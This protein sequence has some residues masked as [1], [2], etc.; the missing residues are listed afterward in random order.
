MNTSNDIADSPDGRLIT[1]SAC[2]LRIPT[3]TPYSLQIKNKNKN[4][5]ISR[6]INRTNLTQVNLDTKS[7]STLTPT[8]NKNK[9][10]EIE[11]FYQNIR[12]LRSRTNEFYINVLNQEHD[13]LAIVETWLHPGIFDSEIIDSRYQVFR[14]DSDQSVTGKELGRGLLLAIRADLQPVLKPDW[15]VLTAELELLWVE[16]TLGF[17]KLQVGLV[18]IMQSTRQEDV[19][20]QLFDHL[21]TKINL[22]PKNL[23][24]LGDF[25]IKYFPYNDQPTTD[26]LS[27]KMLDFITQYEITTH[28]IIPNMNNRT[29]DLVLYK[30]NKKANSKKTYFIN[31]TREDSLVKVEDGHHP[32]LNINI[33]YE[34]KHTRQKRS[35][36]P[37]PINQEEEEADAELTE[38]NLEFTQLGCKLFNYRKLDNEKLIGD[39]SQA[40]WSSVLESQCPNAS[41]SAFYTTLYQILNNN[42][43]HFPD[44]RRKPK[45]SFPTWWFSKTRKIFKEKSQQ[46]FEKKLVH[47]NKKCVLRRVLKLYQM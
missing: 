45:E 39:M 29:L 6:G 15:C 14:Q 25:N 20:T 4:N 7:H 43:P 37:A 33:S 44:K 12:G 26:P 1:D 23:L 16:I 18:Y 47:K 8:T 30:S 19:L 22:F 9:K 38:S 27:L 31:L 2:D 11:I 13:I 28:N 46:V 10:S 40:D 42:V 17:T 41:L 24:L 36:N 32:P 35:Q 34:R 21:E 3:I 5:N